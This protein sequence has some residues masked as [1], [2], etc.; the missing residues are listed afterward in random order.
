MVVFIAEEVGKLENVKHFERGLAGAEVNVSVGLTRLG[1]Q[2]TYITR[3]GDDPYGRCIYDF[4]KSEGVL[5]EGI[6][7]DK[8]YLTGSYL[9]GKVLKGDPDIFYYRKNSAASHMSPEDIDAVDFEGAQWLHITGISLALSQSCRRAAARAIE[10]ARQYGLNVSFDPNI[11]VSLWKSEEEMRRT[12]NEFAFLCDMVLPGLKEGR[13]LT[14]QTSEEGIADFYLAHGCKSVIVKNGG[15]GAFY[16]SRENG[17]R[18]CASGYRV[19]N[20]VDTVGAGDGFATGVISGCLE[21]LALPEAVLR[22]NAIGAIVI[23]GKGDN[24]NLP[25]R[26]TLHAFMA[27]A[28]N[29]DQ[30]EEARSYGCL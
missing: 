15:H 4:I 8:E 24:E 18:G 26:E 29:A 25:T 19:S 2:V 21:G 30:S 11:R 3:L 16:K 5:T 7:T 17:E 9:K 13:L 1:H 12:M 23:M 14:G 6:I 10:K 22:G 28:P 20:I 27:S